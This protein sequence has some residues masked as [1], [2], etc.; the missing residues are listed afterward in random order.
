MLF[1]LLRLVVPHSV[2]VKWPYSGCSSDGTFSLHGNLMGFCYAVWLLQTCLLLPPKVSSTTSG[3]VRCS[4]RCSK[5]LNFIWIIHFG[6]TMCNGRS[7]FLEERSIIP[8]CAPLKLSAYSKLHSAGKCTWRGSTLLKHF[9]HR[10]QCNQFFRSICV[11][12]CWLPLIIKSV[13]HLSACT[14]YE[15]S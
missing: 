9:Q 7:S 3:F 10:K 5:H 4:T 12:Y 1:V 2:P 14:E 6:F 15:K 11:I 8:L 13:L